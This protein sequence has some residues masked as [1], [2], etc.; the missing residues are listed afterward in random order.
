MVSFDVETIEL[1]TSS[2]VVEPLAFSDIH[3]Y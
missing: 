3:V 2:L 1:L